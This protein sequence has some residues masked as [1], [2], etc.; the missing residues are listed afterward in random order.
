VQ[1]RN[2]ELRR[3]VLRV[4]SVST[5][6]VAGAGICILLIS[7]IPDFRASVYASRFLP[8]EILIW[9]VMAA[10]ANQLFFC[11][12]Y[13]FRAHAQEPLWIVSLLGAICILAS[14]LTSIIV[15]GVGA[16]FVY[17]KYSR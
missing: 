5:I 10:I 6:F 11:A 4:G 2:A 16:M 1:G 3:E 14:I 9:L 13:F 15:H 17:Y 8:V 12:N 7:I